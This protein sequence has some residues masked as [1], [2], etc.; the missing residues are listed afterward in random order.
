MHHCKISYELKRRIKC[1]KD[2]HKKRRDQAEIE[3]TF[4]N[5]SINRKLWEF[6]YY[7]KSDLFRT[8]TTP[9]ETDSS[10]KKTNR[11][12]YFCGQVNM[13][14]NRRDRR[15]PWYNQNPSQAQSRIPSSHRPGPFAHQGV[16]QGA[17]EGK[18]GPIYC[19]LLS[20]FA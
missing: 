6:N 8:S 1:Y 13:I 9:G 20:Y 19:L 16:T 7:L 2:F 17:L 14:A 3:P 5:L 12:Q 18:T 11:S 4:C 10:T 15:E